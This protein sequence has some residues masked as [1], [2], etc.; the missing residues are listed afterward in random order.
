MNTMH[1][2]IHGF[3]MAAKKQLLLLRCTHYTAHPVSTVA[4]SLQPTHVVCTPVTSVNYQ[5][6]TNV[7]PQLSE[8]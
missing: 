3:T 8:D 1:P 7:T 6:P 5:T 2:P 4:T